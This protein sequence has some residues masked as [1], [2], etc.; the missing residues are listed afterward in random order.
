MLWRNY[1]RN[2]VAKRKH[3]LWYTLN[4][5]L[6]IICPNCTHG[7][8]IWLLDAG[9]KHW[10]SKHTKP[11]STTTHCADGV[12]LK[13]RPYPISST[14]GRIHC[15]QLISMTLNRWTVTWPVK[16]LGSHTGSKSS[17]RK[18]I[19]NISNN[20]N[21]K[22]TQKKTGTTFKITKQYINPSLVIL[23]HFRR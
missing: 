14:V 7:S 5:S 4:S 13:K 15:K 9:P 8:P 23:P 12:T 6:K 3:V 11:S 10:T 22:T 21:Q 17:W 16:F 18:L 19:I 20:S 2:A 1:K